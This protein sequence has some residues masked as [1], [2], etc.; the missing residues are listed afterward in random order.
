[1]AALAPTLTENADALN[2][3]VYLQQLYDAG[4]RGSFDVLAVQAYGLRGGPDDP[5]VDASDVTFSR[6]TL[7]RAGDG[8]ATAT[9]DGRSGR[10]RWG[11]TSIRRTSP[12]QQF[13]RVTPVAAGALHGAGA[14]SARA[15]SGRG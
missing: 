4:V 11:G 12:E 6:P 5:R 15:S 13:G 9:R 14:S 2:E 7:V 1:M 8:C 10:R 3:L